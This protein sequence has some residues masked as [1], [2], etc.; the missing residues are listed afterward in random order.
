MKVG[1]RLA[2]GNLPDMAELVDGLPQGGALHVNHSPTL[3]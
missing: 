1:N 3:R 2:V